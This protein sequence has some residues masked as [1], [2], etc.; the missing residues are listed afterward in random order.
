MVNISQVS[1]NWGNGG[2]VWG[3]KAKSLKFGI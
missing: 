3:G 1:L 2:I